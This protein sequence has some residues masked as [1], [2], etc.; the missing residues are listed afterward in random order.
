[1]TLVL[2]VQDSQALQAHR[3]AFGFAVDRNRRSCLLVSYE[4]AEDKDGT[5]CRIYSIAIAALASAG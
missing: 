4:I 2:A 3:T 1:L 5:I